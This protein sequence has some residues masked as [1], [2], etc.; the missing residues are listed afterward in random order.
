MRNV[1]H[2]NAVNRKTG[3]I[4]IS[5]ISDK[6]SFRMQKTWI[7]RKKESTDLPHTLK[8]HVAKIAHIKCLVHRSS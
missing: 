5:I 7:Y 3:V 8:G 2:G 6:V 4:W 1:P